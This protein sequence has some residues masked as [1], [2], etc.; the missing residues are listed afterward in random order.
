MK[1]A[2]IFLVLALALGGCISGKR[3]R[4]ER[5]RAENPD[6]E[7]PAV[8]NPDFEKPGGTGS[9]EV[10][11]GAA[12]E[13]PPLTRAE[14][15]EYTESI[16]SVIESLEECY[17]TGDF[18]KWKSLLTPLYKEKHNDPDFL[19]AGGWAASDLKSF[20]RLLIKTRKLV[21]VTSLGVSR[22]EFVNPQ[23]ALVYVILEDSEFPEPQHTF[24]KLGNSWLKGLPEEGE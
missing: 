5:P 13:E 20:F 21:N 1:Y 15:E 16:L 8:E 19:Q 12:G 7:K 17:R 24:L 4:G 3:A 23:K 10:I 2:A 22:V 14:A 6:F 11:P 18:E 9:T